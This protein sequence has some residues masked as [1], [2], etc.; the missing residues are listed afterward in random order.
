MLKISAIRHERLI[1][2]DAGGRQEDSATHCAVQLTGKR[3]LLQGCH[4]YERFGN[5]R[6]CEL[7]CCIIFLDK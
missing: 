5:Y 2:T 3:H 1:A 4:V 6:L 7:Q